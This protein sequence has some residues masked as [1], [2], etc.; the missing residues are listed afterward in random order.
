MQSNVTGTA[1]LECKGLRSL[2][3]SLPNTFQY[4]DSLI[5]WTTVWQGKKKDM[6]ET[7]PLYKIRKSKLREVQKWIKNTQLKSKVS[8]W[9]SRF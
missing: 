2:C 7:F 9:Q 5:P 8:P 3:K 4:T 1:I 6:D